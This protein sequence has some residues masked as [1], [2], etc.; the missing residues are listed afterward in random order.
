MGEAVSVAV[1]PAAGRGTRVSAVTAGRSK[2]MLSLAGLPAI[3]WVIDEALLAG[4][5]Q[6]VVVVRRAK[7]DL[8]DYLRTG[9]HDALVPAGQPDLAKLRAQAELHLTFQPEPV[10][11]GDALSRAVATVGHR[12]FA[13]LYPDNIFLASE[14]AVRPLVESFG[15][16]RKA[17]MGLYPEAQLEAGRGSK[18]GRVLY[19]RAGPY[20]LVRLTRLLDKQQPWPWLYRWRH[21]ALRMI[22]RGALPARFFN[23]IEAAR[24]GVTGELDDIQPLRTLIRDRSCY[25]LPVCGRRFDIGS[26]EGF[27]KARVAFAERYRAGDCP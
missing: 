10:G 22:G 13:I 24:A 26:L 19:R 11:L 23:A 6:V 3:Q 9:Y 16:L 5:T 15:R 14:P 8:V 27:Q 2:E 4:L 12:P 1:I 18:S 25:G 20:G 21:P 7:T 17:V